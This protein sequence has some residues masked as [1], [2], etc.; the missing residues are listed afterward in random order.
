MTS[1]EGQSFGGYRLQRLIGRGGMSEVYLG[2]HLRIPRTVAIKVRPID[3]AFSRSSLSREARHQSFLEHPH[4][5]PIYDASEIYHNNKTYSFIAMPYCPEGSLADWLRLHSD[6]LV[7]SPQNA[8]CIVN[9]VAEALQYVHDKGLTH[10]DIKPENLL[11]RS[12][13]KNQDCP[14]LLLSDFGIARLHDPRSSRLKTKRKRRTPWHAE[15][16]MPGTPIYMPPEQWDADR[17]DSLT[18]ASDQYALAVLTY[19][20]VTGRPPFQEGVLE[21]QH[22]YVQPSPPSTFNPRLPTDVDT[23]VLIGLAKNPEG[24]FASVSAFARAFQQAMQTI[25]ASTLVSIRNVP[26]ISDIRATLAI[27]EAEALRGASRT[28]TLPNG[29]QIIISIP[30]GTSNGQVIRKVLDQPSSSSESVSNLI[31]TIAVHRLGEDAPT[32]KTDQGQT[33]I[34]N[35]SEKAV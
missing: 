14:H 5:L 13:R 2:L 27:S 30:P 28:L 9:Q 8:V 31:L 35:P 6:S 7:S 22:L 34:S 12:N 21:Y 4:I 26:S 32:L 17:S 11:I 33:I 29:Q 15:D 23:V 16:P 24:R 3:S 18:P 1:L 19:V 20:L 10:Q 25:D